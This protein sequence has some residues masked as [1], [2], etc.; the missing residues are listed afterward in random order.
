M[1]RCCDN[2]GFSQVYS[3]DITKS[4]VFVH[5]AKCKGLPEL[6]Q[7]GRHKGYY[8]AQGHQKCA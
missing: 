4:T 8:C 3:M 5:N 6:N 1:H 2:S 7:P